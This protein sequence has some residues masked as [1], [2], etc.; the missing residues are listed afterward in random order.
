M[1]TKIRFRKLPRFRFQALIAGMLEI[2]LL[3]SYSLRDKSLDHKIF[4]KN[5]TTT[6][7]GR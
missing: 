4:N 7:N 6:R 2:A 5:D 1:N 3:K